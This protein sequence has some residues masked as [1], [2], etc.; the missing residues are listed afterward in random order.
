MKKCRILG[1]CA[2]LFL[3]WNA[4][5]QFFSAGDDPY[6]RW[7]QI[8]SRHYRIL[9]PEGTDSLARAY[10]RALEQWQPSVGISTGM[11]AGGLQWG[12]TPVILHPFT[13]HSNGAVTWAPKRIDLYSLP[14][15]YGTLPLSWMTQ[16]AVHE[17]R[18]LAQMQF[19]YRKP[20]RWPHYLLGEM[21][22]G[23]LAALFPNQPLLEGDAV[24]AETA[25]TRSGRGRNADFLNYY[26]VAFDQGDWRDWYQW[27]Y[28]S[29]RKEAPDHYTTGYMTVAGMRYFHDMPDFTAA[30]FDEILR[31]PLP[32]ASLQRFIKKTTGKPFRQAY[33][34]IL[35]GFHGIW[36][37][38][39]DARGP[40]MPMEQVSR[41][42]S[43]ATD[44]V[45]CA[46]SGGRLYVLKEGKATSRRLITLEEDGT[47]HDLGP[48]APETSSL[49]DDGGE[50][51]YWSESVPDL[52][53]T[54]GGASVIRSLDPGTGRKKTLTRTG[55]LYNPVPSEDGSQL[56]IL[57][58]PSV[59]ASRLL[60][61][62]ADSFD[63]PVRT[64]PAPGVQ[65]TEVTWMGETLYAIG[66][67]D[68][69]FSLWRH[70][71]RWTCLQEPSY[72][73][74]ENLG[75]GDGF[76]EYVSDREGVKELYHYFPDSGKTYRITC[77]R[78]GG[79]DYVEA[80][81]WLYYTSQTLSGSLIFR[82]ALDSLRPVEVDPL[83][84]RKD[85]VADELSR[86]EREMVRNAPPAD[87]TLGA[88]KRYR[89]GLHL[90]KF[91]SWAPL[92]FNYDNISSLS[93]DLSYETAS[94]GVTGLFQNELGTASGFIGYSAHK[95]P[96]GNAPWRHSAHAQFT[97][98]GLYP[99]LEASA[100]FNDQALYQYGFREY[101]Q[102][103]DYSLS[104]TGKPLSGPAFHGSVAAYVPFHFSRGGVQRGLVPRISW[105][106]SN[107]RFN[108]SRIVMTPAPGFEGLPGGRNL[109]GIEEGDNV[110]M[111][112]ISASVRGYSMLYSADSQT[113]PRLGIG[114][115][116]GYR[117]RP[118]LTGV[119]A[120]VWYGYLY[121]Y[122][123]GVTPVQGL[124]LTALAQ[125]QQ[126]NGRVF[127]ENQVQI[128]PRGF[129][130]T[131]GSYLARHSTVQWKVTADYAI[132]F[133]LGDLSFLS[134][135]AYIRNFLL[136]PH[137]DYTRCSLGDL[138]SLGAD[139]TAKLGNLAWFPFDCSVGVTVNRLG[140]SLLPALQE[141]ER[142]GESPWQAG[143]IFSMDL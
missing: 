109:T 30:Y 66:V 111:Q 36:A 46:Y 17:S 16:L 45:G 89:K 75:T 82:T 140:G 24:V 27:V 107:N 13:N 115:E 83:V 108:A 37:A 135:V 131:A 22:S 133:S 102:E 68:R 114:A 33:R 93:L 101:R 110:L 84:V 105:S 134:P 67:D 11:E 39:A 59:G 23:V 63:K 52:R 99:V 43:F 79:N 44:Y 139:F 87:E 92:Y 58:Y 70:D 85:P 77:T 129:Q 78:Y 41:T 113:Y 55:R 103:K 119:Y 57:E 21:W 90:L 100:D 2:A 1:L 104:T 35:E 53:W 3:C 28:G 64:I 19:P 9:Y 126:R 4:S 40:Y 98:T 8:Q 29:F 31:R 50:T 120:P 112:T 141:A 14:E 138:F 69:G 10:V 7:W 123:P 62:R 143:L 94:P 34:D 5:A 117:F 80:D 73:S 142:A 65:L 132:P 61:Y 81:G 128:L 122:L 47:E 38:E 96:D 56:A 54:L 86:Q 136:I 72:Q 116:A 74:L 130:T 25:L 118:R 127:G 42:P 26:H 91:H 106:A 88:P 60:V 48:F 125:R 12:T 51:L 20:F 97:Y 6:V 95:D 137:A 32:V 71:G 49:Y 121:G 18:H 124:R 15:A 76:L